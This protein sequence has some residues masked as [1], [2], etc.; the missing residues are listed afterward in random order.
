MIVPVHPVPAFHSS[1]P[2]SSEAIREFPKIRGTLS[3]GPYNKDPTISGTIFGVP[4]F[5]KL[6]ITQTGT[7]PQSPETAEAAHR[8]LCTTN[9]EASFRPKRNRTVRGHER[10]EADRAYHG[11]EHQEVPATE[12]RRLRF[13]VWDSGLVPEIKRLSTPKL[14]APCYRGIS[15]QNP[16]LLGQRMNLNEGDRM[17]KPV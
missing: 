14:Q 1:L 13:C 15:S 7:T 12:R 5:R 3:W 16:N 9:M 10:Y 8:L 2:Q 4:Y 11:D 6:P 17:P